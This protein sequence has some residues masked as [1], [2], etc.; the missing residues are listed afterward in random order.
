[1]NKRINE[2]NQKNNPEKVLPKTLKPD[3]ENN[4]GKA[5]A[6]TLKPNQENNSDYFNAQLVE[7]L[8]EINKTDP[9]SID[10]AEAIETRI[11]EILKNKHNGIHAEL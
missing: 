6:K 9:M 7:H 3:Q 4:L 5:L 2:I 8:H 10:T 1:M 11:N